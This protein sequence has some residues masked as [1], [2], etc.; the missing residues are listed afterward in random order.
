MSLSNKIATH[1]GSVTAQD[2][3]KK[4][5]LFE[6]LKTESSSVDQ[7]DITES[8][9]D[10]SVFNYGNRE[11]LILTD[12]EAKTKAQGYIR[13]SLWAFNPTF[14]QHFLAVPIPEK[15]M[16]KMQEDMSEGANEI[17]YGLVKDKFES[18]VVEAIKSDGRGHFIAQ[19]DGKEVP[20][21]NL[22]IYRIN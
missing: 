9:D 2:E 5:A 6:Y 16:K 21:G 7:E 19:Y 1:Y 15:Y 20:A 14:L 18:L 10:P 13:D 8:K 12:E 3:N 4:N 17:V 22:F 11:Y